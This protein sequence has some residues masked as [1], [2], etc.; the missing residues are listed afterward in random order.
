MATAYRNCQESAIATLRERLLYI[1]NFC[2]P[3]PNTPRTDY[4]EYGH[5]KIVVE[6]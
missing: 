4:V 3:V 5:G 2:N 1:I 6:I